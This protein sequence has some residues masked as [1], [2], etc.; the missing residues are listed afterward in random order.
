MDYLPISIFSFR[1]SNRCGRKKFCIWSS[2]IRDSGVKLCTNNGFEKTYKVYGMAKVALKW[3]TCSELFRWSAWKSIL[4]GT[5]RQRLIEIPFHAN[6]YRAHGHTIRFG[7]EIRLDRLAIITFHFLTFLF[8]MTLS[9]WHQWEIQ[10]ENTKLRNWIDRSQCDIFYNSAKSLVT[11]SYSSE[12]RIHQLF[13][14]AIFFSESYF[15]GIISLILNVEQ[16]NGVK[17]HA[18]INLWQNRCLMK[19]H[20]NLIGLITISSPVIEEYVINYVQKL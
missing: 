20:N 6:D 18:F 3:R 17:D 16:Q 1:Q 7:N 5:N 9:S 10:I 2:R 14:K 8:P 13:Y 12:R 19:R 11:A 4:I 15:D